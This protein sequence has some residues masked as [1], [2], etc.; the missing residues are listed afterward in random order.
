MK[1]GSDTIKTVRIKL[2]IN[3]TSKPLFYSKTK[4]NHKNNRLLNILNYTPS[5]IFIY[6]NSI[7]NK[8]GISKNL[9]F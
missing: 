8:C 2:L 9:Y 3:I 7:I 6:F 5:V 4:S 1:L